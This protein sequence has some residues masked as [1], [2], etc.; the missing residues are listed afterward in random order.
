MF[1]FGQS[2]DSLCIWSTGKYPQY[3]TYAKKKQQKNCS[4]CRVFTFMYTFFLIMFVYVTTCFTKKHKRQKSPVEIVSPTDV[5]M[6]LACIYDCVFFLS[7]L[8]VVTE[9]K[10]TV[11]VLFFFNVSSV[12]SKSATTTDSVVSSSTD[13]CRATWWET[14]QR[15]SDWNQ[16][17]CSFC[18]AERAVVK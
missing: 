14:Y 9:P 5:F 11:V 2:C 15:F 3:K 1:S 6:C 7:T 17:I 16:P 13:V 18:T 12:Q 8:T 4:R 10:L